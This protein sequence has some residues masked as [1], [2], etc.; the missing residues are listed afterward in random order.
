MS[1]RTL[2]KLAAILALFSGLA[3]T[4]IPVQAEE[5]AS[6]SDKP[7]SGKPASSENHPDFVYTTEY[8]QKRLAEAGQAPAVYTNDDLAA[9][10]PAPAPPAAAYTNDDLKERFG[11][12]AAPAPEP[13][14][15]EAVAPEAAPAPAAPPSEPAPDA[16]ER[17]QR[18]T[19]ID[20]ELARLD[21]R[22]LAI[23][24]PL[25]AGTVPPTPEEREAEAGLDNEQRLAQ[26]EAKIAE[27]K[28]AL[29]ELK[30]DLAGG[31]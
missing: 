20:E 7:A 18:I 27:L 28:A 2:V 15:A 26:T 4:E 17:A 10:A 6:G 30:R 12:E 9:P 21:K 19:E 23:R 25:L 14:A 13:G 29:E 5:Q 1:K 24:N 31:E 11:D 8:L 3:T 16:A 22:L